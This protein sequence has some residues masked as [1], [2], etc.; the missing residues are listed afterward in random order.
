MNWINFLRKKIFFL[1][2]L[3][4]FLIFAWIWKDYKKIDIYFVNQS[5]IT[6]NKKNLN[7]NILKKLDSLINNTLENFLITYSKSHKNYWNVADNDGR[8]KLPEYKVLKNKKKFTESNNEKPLNFSNWERSHGNNSSNRFSNLKNINNKNVSNLEVAWTFKMDDNKGA[9]QANP[10]IANGIIYTPMA[11]GYIVA[12]DGKSG[13]LLWKSRKFENTVARRGL[14][15]WK[16]DV[17]KIGRIIFS[18][19]QKLISL[20]ASN[21]EFI[22]SFG[23]DGQV[24]TGLNVLTPVIYKNNIIIVTWD[25]AI[26]VYDLYSGKNKW[27]L[28]YIKNISKRYGG[29][30]FNNNGSNPWGGISLDETRGILYFTTGNPHYYFDGTQRPGTNPNSSSLLA[31]DLKEKKILWSFQ[32]TSHD[33]WNSDL[34]APPILT[35]IIKNN[36]KIDVVVAP[37]KRSNTL[38]LDRLTG[39]P[40]FDFR[41]RKAPISK[42]PG[43]K[44]NYYQPDLIIPE[45]FGRNIFTKKDLW[46]YDEEIEKEIKKKYKNYEYGFYQPYE[47]GKKTLQYNFNGGAEWMGGSVDHH[48]GIMYVTSNNILWETGIKI[49]KKNKTLT[50]KYKSIFKRALDKNGY[51]VIRPPWGALTALNLNNGK[52]IWQVP[53]GGFDDLKK[54]GFPNTGSENFGGVTATAGDIAI[55]TGTLDKKIYV[56]DIKDGA[57]L[58]S[59]KLPFIGSAPPSTYMYNEEQYI[60]LHSS[61]GNT[62]TQGYP[63]LVEKGNVLI[64]F[65]LKK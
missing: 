59:K 33:I 50:P 49:E 1:F 10:I 45:P 62:L 63:N 41:L 46:S 55:A 53:F 52:I 29:K 61:G 65:K 39:E 6:Y 20:N 9:I 37:T 26:E 40:V 2:I 60:V 44:T 11:G 8:D 16:D 5:K 47:L 18:N 38:I 23:K 17:N 51:P 58:Y 12:I 7:S 4:A 15:Y 35:S 19:R 34:P 30:K 48:N 13:K 57:I 36:N 3:F 14:L 27:K 32:E 25:R 28:K 54:L 56:F 21:G 42:L 43:E 22:E 31:I 64:A 24:R